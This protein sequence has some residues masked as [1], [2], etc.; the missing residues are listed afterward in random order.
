MRTSRF[1]LTRRR[2]SLLVLTLTATTTMVLSGCSYSR[3][4][5][6][7][8]PTPQQVD[9]FEHAVRFVYEAPHARHVNLC[10]N[11]SDNSWCGTEGSGRFDNNVGAMQDDN[12]DGIWEIVI[13][14]KPGRYIYKFSLDWGI[15]WEQDQNNPLGEA[16]GFGGQNSILILN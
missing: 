5:R 12:K 4:L 8:L 6:N 16:D 2:V 3:I 13:P 11:W 1:P 15:R 10:G 9:D 14:L 7:R